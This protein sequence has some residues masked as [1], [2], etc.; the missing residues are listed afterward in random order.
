MARGV[1]R[2]CEELGAA[3]PAAPAAAAHHAASPPKFCDGGLDAAVDAVDT[4]GAAAAAADVFAWSEGDDD[5]LP[6]CL[7][8]RRVSSIYE[9]RSPRRQW[10]LVLLMSCSNVLLPFTN[11][12]FIPAIG[13]IT[14]EFNSTPVMTALAISIFMF[15]TG[16]A[17]LL[18][19]PFADRWGRRRTLLCAAVLFLGFSVGCGLARRIELLVAF[20]ALQG[21]A[22]ACFG[23]TA[24]AVVA[25]V[26]SPAQR[27]KAMGFASLPVL[28]GPILGPLVGGGLSQALG[29]RSTFAAM[30]I[31]GALV[32]A[33]LLLFME[34]THHH[35]VLHR[36]RST[37][38]EGAAAAIQEAPSI[39]RP[40]FAAP[41]RGLILLADPVLAPH[42]LAT[43]AQYGT[44]YSCMMVLPTVLAAPPYSLSQAVIGA[45]NMAL[46]FGLLIS[47]PLAGILTDR[48][49]KTWPAAPTGRVLFS[50]PAALVASPLA[51]LL[52]GWSLHFRLH[53]G[54]PLIGCVFVGVG[55]GAYA[56][57]TSSLVS[58]THQQNAAAAGGAL[59][60][61]MFVMGGVFTQV[62]PIGLATLGVGPFVS[63][64]AAL[65][66]TTLSFALARS[67][68]VVR[69]AAAA[70]A[71]AERL[72]SPPAAVA[73]GAKDA[74]A[75]G[76]AVAKA[77]GGEPPREPAAGR[78]EAL[79]EVVVAG[80]RR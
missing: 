50:A 25:D 27:G 43:V 19:G 14:H 66:A 30:A 74:A 68:A 77:P 3:A 35:Y 45:T 58:I 18:W 10:L 21:L 40:K 39:R 47:A 17:S 63:I 70:A 57:A 29:W 5:G 71:A 52:V 13:A 33:A 23:V 8:A 61:S 48:A 31:F 11:T 28:V 55:M 69:R 41:W 7:E 62:T 59:F 44:L 51:A 42:V 78:A 79:V 4:S 46:G 24:N 76:P 26:F 72:P 1:N 65:T 67:I 54:L 2:G 34:E 37:R 64:M 49:A 16:S 53:L 38:G 73:A 80:E 15:A 9:V 20:R 36:I 56:P 12:A 60:A 32:L 22:V 75:P 6:P